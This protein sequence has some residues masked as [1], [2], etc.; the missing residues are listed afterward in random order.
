VLNHDRS[1]IRIGQQRQQ[2]RA[3]PVQR[4]PDLGDYSIHREAVPA[5][6]DGYPCYLPVK[7]L[8]LIRGPH[9]SVYG[10]HPSGHGGRG[11]VD[12]DQPTD[13]GR[14]DRELTLP[15]PPVRGDRVHPVRDSPLSQIHYRMY[16]LL[17]SN[18]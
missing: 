17:W 7:V 16:H 18:S 14:G 10:G 13:T 11:L 4:G 6:P 8:A 1:D 9:A 3:A 2:L 15:E 12:E 5:R